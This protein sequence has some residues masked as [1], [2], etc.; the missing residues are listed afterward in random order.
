[1]ILLQFIAG[2]QTEKR[3]RLTQSTISVRR[4]FVFGNDGN[5]I[6]DDDKRSVNNRGRGN[7]LARASGG[8]GGGTTAI[9][10]SIFGYLGPLDQGTGLDDRNQ[11]TTLNWLSFQTIYIPEK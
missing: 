5:W 11:R 8:G 10:L 3:E 2:V 9:V 4:S 1:M 6:T 7:R